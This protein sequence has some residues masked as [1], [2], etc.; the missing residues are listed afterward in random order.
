MSVVGVVSAPALSRRW[1]AGLGLEARTPRSVGR[2]RDGW[3]SRCGRPRVGE[4]VVLR[5]CPG[6]PIAAP[7]TVSSTSPTRCGGCAA[8]GTSTHCLVAEGARSTWHANRRSSSGIWR[9]WTCWSG[10]RRHLHQPFREP[11]RARRQ[12]G[13]EQWIAAQRGTR[14]HRHVTNST[15]A[16]ELPRLIPTLE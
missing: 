16:A 13:C 6:G 4:P 15:A 10:S 7:V 9:R 2:I 12:R 8:A 11:G 1:W 3:P 14:L 5:A